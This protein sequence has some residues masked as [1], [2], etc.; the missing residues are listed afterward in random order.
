MTPAKCVRCP[1]LQLN[2]RAL[3]CSVVAMDNWS[4]VL[5]LLHRVSLSLKQSRQEFSSTIYCSLQTSKCDSWI[6]YGKKKQIFFRVT[7]DMPPWLVPGGIWRCIPTPLIGTV[8]DK[9]R[10]AT[11]QRISSRAGSF[12]YGPSGKTGCRTY[13]GFCSVGAW[14]QKCRGVQLTT[15]SSA[16]VRNEW[17][18]TSTPFLCF[19]D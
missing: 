17:S 10:I 14:R 19:A 6:W 3:L 4:T 1:V 5:F 12:T 16:E 2:L 9:T 18:Y 11:L 8:V 7:V 13:P 15:V